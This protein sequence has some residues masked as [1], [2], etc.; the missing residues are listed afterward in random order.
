MA[1]QLD[2]TIARATAIRP[3]KLGALHMPAAIIIICCGGSVVLTV[4]LDDLP[5]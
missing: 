2:I 1:R 4:T 3:W 5:L